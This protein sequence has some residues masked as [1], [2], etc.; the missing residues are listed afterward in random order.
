M[1]I[2]WMRLHMVVGLAAL[3]ALPAAAQS[4]A[5]KT[6]RLVPHADLT[7]VDPQFI[8]VC[9]TRNFGYLVDDT[10]FGMDRDFHPQP[11]MVDTWQISGDK[12]RPIRFAC[13]T[14]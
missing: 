9:I 7:V 14:A 5:G 11:E 4:D 6:L 12:L 1:P 13:A 10:L 2:T 8:G 3:S